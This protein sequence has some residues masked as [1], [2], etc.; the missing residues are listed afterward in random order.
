[1]IDWNE[2]RRNSGGFGQKGNYFISRKCER[3]KN[4]MK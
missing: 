2:W 3:R 1:M 4:K